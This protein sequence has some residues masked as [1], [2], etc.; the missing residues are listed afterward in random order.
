MIVYFAIQ[1]GGEPLIHPP[2]QTN[3]LANKDLQSVT[4]VK[5]T[6]PAFHKKFLGIILS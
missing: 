3:K 5:L 4:H 2:M 6:F 1:D